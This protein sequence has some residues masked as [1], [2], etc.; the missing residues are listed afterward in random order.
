V[1]RP[2]SRRDEGEGAP[3][4]PPGKVQIA[5]FNYW[6]YRFGWPRRAVVSIRRS[7]LKRTHDR[8][9]RSSVYHKALFRGHSIEVL[10]YFGD[11]DPSSDQIESVN[12]ILSTIRHAPPP[13]LTQ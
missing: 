4:T 6:R 5:I 12:R 7:D 13:K 9:S 1:L 11:S 8:V 3:P 10:V 2:F